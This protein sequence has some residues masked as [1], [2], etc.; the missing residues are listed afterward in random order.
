LSYSPEW[1]GRESNPRTTASFAAATTTARLLCRTLSYPAP[2]NPGQGLEPWSPRSERGVLPARRSRSGGHL[3]A[4]AP[5]KPRLSVHLRTPE[6]D[7]VG[8]RFVHVSAGKKPTDVFQATR[9]PFD[10]GSPIAGCACPLRSSSYVEELWSPP[11]A[12]WSEK[13]QAKADAIVRALFHAAS[14]ERLSLS[15]GAS[16]P[17]MNVSSWASPSFR[18][19]VVAP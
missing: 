2:G 1:T 19:S 8:D 11:L 12:P 10:P 7:A 9:Q 5:A 14:A 16:I 15:G 3:V 4:E 13:T 17:S 18:R 6:I